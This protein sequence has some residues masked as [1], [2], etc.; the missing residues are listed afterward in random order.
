MKINVYTT[1]YT[2]LI[3]VNHM[4]LRAKRCQWRTYVRIVCAIVTQE[5]QINM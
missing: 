3:Y 5:C 1:I 2:T 4:R